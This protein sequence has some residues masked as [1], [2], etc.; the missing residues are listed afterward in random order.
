M[1]WRREA[2]PLE[3]I[4]RIGQSGGEDGCFRKSG[5]A[6]LQDGGVLVEPR[7]PS[8][9]KRSMDTTHAKASASRD[10]SNMNRKKITKFKKQNFKSPELPVKCDKATGVLYKAQLEKGQCSLTRAY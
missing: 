2:L 8:T 3:T 7:H 1:P 10:S 9:P 4:E 5:R 6:P